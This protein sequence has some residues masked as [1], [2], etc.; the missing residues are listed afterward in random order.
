MNVT[1]PRHIS[2]HISRHWTI[3]SIS[4]LVCV[5]ACMHVST[6]M[7]TCVCVCV[8]VCVCMHAVCVCVC[9]CVPVSV[10]VCLHA[11]EC[12]AC[13]Q[14]SESECIL[15]VTEPTSAGYAGVCCSWWGRPCAG[16]HRQSALPCPPGHHMLHGSPANTGSYARWTSCDIPTNTQLLYHSLACTRIHKHKILCHMN[17]LWHTNKQPVGIHTHTHTLSLSSLLLSFTLKQE[18]KYLVQKSSLGFYTICRLSDSEI[19]VFTKMP[20]SITKTVPWEVFRY[21]FVVVVYFSLLKN[22]PCLS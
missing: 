5:H 17:I 15:C 6:Y 20:K 4:I 18:V 1:S 10:R 11:W 22:N 8:C 2:V 7:R 3:T 14:N 21:S 19:S 9:V 16:C 13:E 12:G